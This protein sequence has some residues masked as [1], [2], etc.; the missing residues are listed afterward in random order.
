MNVGD[1]FT[2]KDLLP[3]FTFFDEALAQG[4]YSE[5][6]LYF[7]YFKNSIMQI[8]T[9]IELYP[10]KQESFEAFLKDIDIELSQPEL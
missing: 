8:P 4:E 2:E 3:L 10:F 9:K 7:N 1:N 5:V 6:N